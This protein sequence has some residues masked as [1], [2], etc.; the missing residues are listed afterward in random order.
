M[1]NLISKLRLDSAKGNSKNIWLTL[2]LIFLLM[3]LNFRTMAMSAWILNSLTITISG[4]QIISLF[5][6]GYW[7]IKMWRTIAQDGRLVNVLYFC[8]LLFA[9]LLTTDITRRIVFHNG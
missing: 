2:I 3:G 5:A 8:L 1:T 6:Y 9:T 4:F 7:T